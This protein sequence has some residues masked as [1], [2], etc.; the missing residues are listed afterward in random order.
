MKKL[1]FIV[2]L[3]FSPVLAFSQYYWEVG[4]QLGVSNYLGEMGGEEETRKDF[5]ADIKMNQTRWSG[6]GFVRYK[7]GQSISVKGGI[8]YIRIQGADSLSQNPGRVGRN[9]SFRNDIF[10][11]TATAQY[12]FYEIND[13]GHTYRYRNDFRVYGFAG[14]TG[15]Y[16]NPKT[17]F[18][19]EWVALQP[20]RTEGQIEPY[21]KIGLGIP[22][23]VGLYFTVEK[24]HRIG[25]ELNWTKTFT[26]YLDDVSTT[27]AP[28]ADP[29]VADIANRNDELT[30]SPSSDLPHPANYTEGSKR[31]DP[32]HKDN[33]MY[34]TVSYSYVLRGKSSFYRSR[35][36][37]H[38][39]K[40][41]KYKKRK[42][43]AKF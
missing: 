37:N 43:R 3:A 7:A 27:Y 39:F 26:D 1:L 18:N 19:G 38:I 35:Y 28:I 41:K 42:K 33:Y 31:G 16:H 5:V 22:M 17:N 32:T 6:G 25:W 11:L 9:L 30:Y 29:Y 34:T 36:S 14:L 2:S 21:S 40:G 23:G 15:F 8:N 20:L 24:R 13:L 10:E 4:G 12:F